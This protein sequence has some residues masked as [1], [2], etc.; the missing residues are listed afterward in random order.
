MEDTYSIEEVAHLISAIGLDEALNRLDP[1]MIRDVTLSDLWQMAKDSF[2][3][4]NACQEIE[5]Y[6]NSEIY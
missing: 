5:E 6:I 4:Q 2:K 3:S 1:D